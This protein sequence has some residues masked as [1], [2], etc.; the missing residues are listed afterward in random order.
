MK[1]LKSILVVYD[2]TDS[3]S[4]ALKQ[5]VKLA[6][7]GNCEVSV[8]IL[9]TSS[10]GKPVLVGVKNIGDSRK[11]LA[12]KHRI[13]PTGDEEDD[14]IQTVL[15]RDNIHK[16]IVNIAVDRGCDLIIIGRRDQSR[17]ERSFMESVTAKVIGCSPVDVLVMPRD[18]VVKWDNILLATDGSLCSEAATVKA[19]NIARNFNS[20]LNV[21]SVVNIPDEAYAEA[22]RVVDQLIDGARNLVESVKERAEA[23]RIKSSTVVREGV[24]HEKI[25]NTASDL[26]VDVICMGN[27]GRTGLRRLIMGSVTEKVIRRATCPVLVVKS[28]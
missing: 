17:S 16:A 28:C 3:K 24:P 19:L 13:I 4:N 22:P 20:K 2:S 10:R 21:V 18:T 12:D 14:R 5:A 7:K 11:G 26:N 1:R 9:M 8:A 6:D 15:E 23:L 27:Y 25:K